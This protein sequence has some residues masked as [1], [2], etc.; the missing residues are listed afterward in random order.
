MKKMWWTLGVFVVF[1]G[2][3]FVFN[4][5]IYHTE[6][7][8]LADFPTGKY[9]GFIHALTD[10]GTSMDFDDAVWL[11]GTEA[12]DAAIRANLC[13]EETRDECTPNGYFIENT[14]PKD[15]RVSV[16]LD[17]SVTMQTWKMEETGQVME[18]D[19]SLSEFADLINDPALHWHNLPYEITVKD[20]I[21]THIAEI[22]VP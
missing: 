19:L 15:E 11:T 2:G 10:N 9:L 20:N 18:Q 13:T 7:G 3:F 21:V 8:P 5:Y 6:Q 4:S 17:A 14:T 22:Y 1:I 12:E 16:S